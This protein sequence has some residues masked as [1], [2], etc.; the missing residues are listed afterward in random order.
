M[1]GEKHNSS[2]IRCVFEGDAEEVC[3]LPEKKELPVCINHIREL[4]EKING[5]KIPDHLREN[6][7][8]K[9]RDS[10]IFNR[11]NGSVYSLN[12]TGT[13]FLKEIISGKDTRTILENLRQDFDVDSMDEAVRDFQSF[14]DEILNI[15]LA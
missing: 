15:G 11:Q 12:A 4:N 9:G 7:L 13:F 2:E 14:L 8:E 10:F 1:S 3:P 6:L 5:T